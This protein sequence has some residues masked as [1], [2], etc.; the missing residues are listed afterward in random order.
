MPPESS[1]KKNI[2]KILNKNIDVIDISIELCLY[3]IRTWI[4][5][6]SNK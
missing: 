2:E 4:F 3:C 5:D 6:D 1:V